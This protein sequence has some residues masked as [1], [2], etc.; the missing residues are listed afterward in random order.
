MQW[1]ELNFW[2]NVD[3]PTNEAAKLARNAK[4]KELREN[5]HKVSLSVCRNQLRPY[6]GLCQPDGRI[7]NVYSIRLVD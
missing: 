3:Y 6:S 1:S 5:G 7:G 2:G 4:A